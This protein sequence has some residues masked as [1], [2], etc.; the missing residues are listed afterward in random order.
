MKITGIIWMRNVVDKLAWKHNVI[1]DE[2][3]VVFNHSPRYRFIE[4]GDVNGEN[5]YVALGRTDAGRY[6]IVYFI[7]KT[8]GEALVV[9]AREM[10]KKERKTYAKK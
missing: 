5:L 9:S 3:E 1:T 6:L 2:V 7:Y 4:T 8:T 10:T